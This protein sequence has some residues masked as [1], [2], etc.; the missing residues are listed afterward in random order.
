MNVSKSAREQERVD[1]GVEVVH[2]VREAVGPGVDL[3]I[4]LHAQLTY[5]GG[6]RFARGVRDANVLFL[7]EPVMPDNNRGYDKLVKKIEAPIAAGERVFTRFAY[8]DMLAEQSR[9]IVQP[10]LTHVGGI[11]ET[12]IIGDMANRHHVKIAPHNSNSI[13]AT[14]ASAV[15]D[16]TMPNFLIQE[17]F[18]EAFLMNGQI[19]KTPVKIEDGY[20]YLP[21]GPGLG[22]EPDWEFIESV[23]YKNAF[24][25]FFNMADPSK[26]AV[27]PV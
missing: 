16:C 20:L 19:L 7:E 18:V 21:E 11:L 26:T 6:L 8:K 12:K 3:C 25:G 23:G 4:E 24:S 27:A 22:I 15:A 1:E 2:A 13:I 9:S 10:D 14:L 5:D 17:M